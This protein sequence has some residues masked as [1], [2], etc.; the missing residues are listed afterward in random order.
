MEIIV[1]ALI[2]GLVVYGLERNKVRGTTRSNLAGSTD[3]QDRDRERF[4]TE[5]FTRA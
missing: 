3:I 4:S 1:L 5:L 2:I